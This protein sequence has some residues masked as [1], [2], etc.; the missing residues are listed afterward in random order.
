MVLVASGQQRCQQ[1]RHICHNVA[2]R[3]GVNKNCS[4][5]LPWNPKRKK[6]PVI[7]MMCIQRLFMILP[8][9]WGLSR[10]PPRCV[11]LLLL[12][13]NSWL[14]ALSS[15]QSFTQLL[16][17]SSTTRTLS[18]Y[19]EI[20]DAPRVVQLWGYSVLM[21]QHTIQLESE[22]VV[23]TSLVPVILF[24]V[25]YCHLTLNGYW[26]IQLQWGFAAHAARVHILW[27]VFKITWH[28]KLE[29]VGVMGVVEIVLSVSRM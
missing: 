2:Y 24:V 19:C 3:S 16:F 26:L 6:N 18:V 28:F 5:L 1:H 10:F 25:L 12:Q 7:Q 15:R 23:Q 20:H 13:L 11:S 27:N 14:E 4:I 8:L 21:Q 9:L 29:S 22:E 17:R